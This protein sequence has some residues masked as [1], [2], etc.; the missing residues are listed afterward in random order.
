MREG[1]LGGPPA[2]H[3]ASQAHK[4]ESGVSTI[5]LYTT[6]AHP[7]RWG[8][9][10]AGPGDGASAE[11]SH[12]VRG[13]AASVSAAAAPV[14]GPGAPPPD[15]PGIHRA[16]LAHPTEPGHTTASTGRGQERAAWGF[17]G[18]K[19]FSSRLWAAPPLR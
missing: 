1:V 5:A 2:V 9:D 8:A 19:T 3:A 13:P 17:T 14:A 4:A 11:P 12:V 16:G 18:A 7:A 6:R 15:A 10:Q